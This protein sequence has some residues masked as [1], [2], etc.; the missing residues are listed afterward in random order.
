MNRLSPVTTTVPTQFKVEEIYLERY[1]YILHPEYGWLK[2]WDED[3]DGTDA[4]EDL[5]DYDT[6]YYTKQHK[7]YEFMPEENQHEP[8]AYDYDDIPF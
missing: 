5:Q 7:T 6:S 1:F 3:Y 4:F 2:G 8:V